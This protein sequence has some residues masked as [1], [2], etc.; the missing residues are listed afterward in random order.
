FL[1][2]AI[3]YIDPAGHK[4]NLVRLVLLQKGRPAEGA[5]DGEPSFTG[6]H[7]RL[8]FRSVPQVD[9]CPLCHGKS[10]EEAA[11][12]IRLAGKK[13]PVA[14]LPVRDNYGSRRIGL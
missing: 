6:G 10:V 4:N 11:S 8:P 12:T 7:A 5:S 14:R 9:C 13:R 1:S 2:S 3:L